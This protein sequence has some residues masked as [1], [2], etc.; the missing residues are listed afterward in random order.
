MIVISIAKIL[1]ERSLA[2]NGL[3]IEAKPEF[4]LFSFPIYCS[5]TSFNIVYCHIL[6]GIKM[7]LELINKNPKLSLKLISRLH[8]KVF[9]LIS[10]F[11]E[12]FGTSLYVFLE[13]GVIVYTFSFY[14]LY[15]SITNIEDDVRQIGLCVFTNIMNSYGFLS[16]VLFFDLSR[17]V[18]NESD[19]ILRKFNDV[20]VHSK[21]KTLLMNQISHYEII[22]NSPFSKI[23]WKLY[24]FVSF[25]CRICD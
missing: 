15:R 23:D 2:Q 3:K 24:L 10:N 22:V 14:D 18:K 6:I 7:R 16:T 12:I 5:I 11:N 4:F 13:F 21:R 17:R 25:F 20:G 8:L 9:E 1:I 19:E